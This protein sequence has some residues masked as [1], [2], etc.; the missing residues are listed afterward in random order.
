[1]SD[2]TFFTDVVSNALRLTELSEFAIYP[3]RFAARLARQLKNFGR[4]QKE[5]GGFGRKECMSP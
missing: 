4:A 1:M 5:R 2:K 3:T